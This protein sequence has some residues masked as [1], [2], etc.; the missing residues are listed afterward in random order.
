MIVCEHFTQQDLPGFRAST[1][2]LPKP[3]RNRTLQTRRTEKGTDK[4]RQE[5]RLACFLTVC[6]QTNSLSRARQ[7]VSK[8]ET[9]GCHTTL[10]IPNKIIRQQENPMQMSAKGKVKYYCLH[11]ILSVK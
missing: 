7:L 6:Q 3:F 10:E 5:S 2:L 1:P 8:T 11:T 4:S 9:R